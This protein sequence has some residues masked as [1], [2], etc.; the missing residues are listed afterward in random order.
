MYVYIYI[1][2]YIFSYHVY[3]NICIVLLYYVILCVMINI[4]LY[5]NHS[6]VEERIS[7]YVYAKRQVGDDGQF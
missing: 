3:Y 7:S 5:S 2:I 4:V 6:P 1:Y